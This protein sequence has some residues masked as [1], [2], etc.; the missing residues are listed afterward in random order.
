MFL[1]LVFFFLPV[2]FSSRHRA[3]RT[4]QQEKESERRKQEIVAW[5]GS[6][7][8]LCFFFFSF[9]FLLSPLRLFVFRLATLSE[10][11]GDY[12]SS[13]SFQWGAGVV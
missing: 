7:T 1:A 6:V 5:A 13:N 12:S 11:V 3:E 9:S 10:C 8:F 4:S 2:F